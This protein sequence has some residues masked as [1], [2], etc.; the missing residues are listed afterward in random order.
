VPY[1][2]STLPWNRPKEDEE[3]KMRR[4]YFAG[5]GEEDPGGTTFGKWWA[6]Q[7]YRV[8]MAL[9]AMATRAHEFGP[10]KYGGLG[11]ASRMAETAAPGA[12]GWLR[13]TG[14]AMGEAHM[15][16]KRELMDKLP[17][18]FAAPPP[19]I[20]DLP[21][22]VPFRDK[23]ANVLQFGRDVGTA[24]VQ[25][26]AL[27]V[28]AGEVAD[29]L[30]FIPA[31][32][33]GK[34]TGATK[35]L[36][37][38][39]KGEV[40]EEVV[41]GALRE[42]D[43]VTKQL[44]KGIDLPP[45]ADPQ[46][47]KE[48]GDT[49]QA[50]KHRGVAQRLPDGTVLW[51]KPGDNHA[52]LLE[53]HGI[54]LDQPDK[55]GERG[56]Q[57]LDPDTGKVKYA[58]AD[59]LEGLDDLIEETLSPKP[60]A[61][62]PGMTKQEARDVLADIGAGDPDD[63]RVVGGS[64]GE[65][66]GLEGLSQSRD[67]AMA[68]AI[69]GGH[70][71]E[72]AH[73][74]RSPEGFPRT[75]PAEPVRRPDVATNVLANAKNTLRKVLSVH[76]G[77]GDVADDIVNRYSA[78]ISE[79]V[80]TRDINDP[81]KVLADD[82]NL[83][84]GLLREHMMDIHP[85]DAMA[86][87][88]A[89]VG[90]ADDA[91]KL[92]NAYLKNPTP[93]AL[94]ELT[95]GM[96]RFVT[97]TSTVSGETGAGLRALQN[98]GK[99]VTQKRVLPGRGAV[100][101]AASARPERLKVRTAFDDDL[102]RGIAG[103]DPDRP[104]DLMRFSRTVLKPRLRDYVEESAFAS[105]LSS[106]E[107]WMIGG[108]NFMG[109]MAQLVGETAKVVA[110]P[111]A[112]IERVV[113]KGGERQ[114]LMRDV[115][116][117]LTAMYGEGLMKGLRNGL[118]VLKGAPAP[119]R[120]GT[121]KAFRNSP[122]ALMRNVLATPMESPGRALNAMDAVFRSMAFHGAAA[123][124]IAARSRQL[125]KSADELPD[126]VKQL[127]TDMPDDIFA[128]AAKQGRYATYTDEV[129]DFIKRLNQY[130]HDPG[131]GGTASRMALPFI[132]ISDR[133]L[134][135][136][137]DYTPFG[138]IKSGWGRHSKDVLD[139]VDMA[140]RAL[141]GTFATAG[142]VGGILAGKSKVK[143]H[144]GRMPK[145]KVDRDRYLERGGQPYTAEIGNR[146]IPFQQME[147]VGLGL[148]AIADLLDALQDENSDDA[149]IT[150]KLGLA[151]M[152]I[153]KGLV[154]PHSIGN[155]VDLI[156]AAAYGDKKSWD[157]WWTRFASRYTAPFGGAQRFAARQMDPTV[158]ETEG[159]GLMAQ[160]N[161]LVA[162]ATGQQGVARPG[163]WGEPAERRKIA[164]RT[165]VDA[166]VNTAEQDPVYQEL[167]K[168]GVRPHMG[169]T[170]LRAVGEDRELSPEQRLLFIR[171]SNQPLHDDIQKLMGRPGWDKVPE[172]SKAKV[173]S[174]LRSRYHQRAV[175]LLRRELEIVHNGRMTDQQKERSL[176]ALQ[177]QVA[178]LLG[179]PTLDTLPGLPRGYRP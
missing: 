161:P 77:S 82:L 117:E 145:N 175:K 75:P 21:E 33:L 76:K 56:F 64:V 47:F 10:T 168:T 70:W 108:R 41:D 130:R 62:R 23:V 50:I 134:A 158:R 92:A 89:I 58:P 167:V 78:Q 143:L 176:A 90:S 87:H 146:L 157:R 124:R 68:R 45:G 104:G 17:G 120:Y 11:M 49:L 39:R 98:I 101:F 72:A 36:R 166:L 20:E 67:L 2:P 52:T 122:S 127:W 135:H 73:M 136:G 27:A 38:F 110:R 165:P 107:T 8:P 154:D 169:G 93:Q 19:V 69:K 131:F 118:A 29:P 111:L 163:T 172:A 3:D 79:S 66:R 129:S 48:V 173:Y 140:S 18:S 116:A 113:R 153:T 88:G 144:G 133:L 46:R 83:D 115:P 43:E 141:V 123:G 99:K 147:G 80:L 149:S 6:K 138:L 162:M 170:H 102:I 114:F 164:T 178:R 59:E 132:N 7:T 32:W 34:A 60:A 94:S 86:V 44:G 106:P 57:V 100:G 63:L 119:G 65:G 91:V 95:D 9:G 28:T 177:K 15:R 105:M 137:V 61:D 55:F 148:R 16:E 4:L 155:L 125:A 96:S 71:E 51:G 12:V 1:N 174:G 103:M 151:A 31:A 24:V 152:E 126:V 128:Y 74:A 35:A 159:Q 30:A 142:I 171:L 54:P 42:L 53:R 81:L 37:R 156:S 97:L 109:N 121:F 40:A 22:W 13:E 112:D 160:T 84:K 14:G 25:A 85:S 179:M 139:Q 150:E 5:R 26:P